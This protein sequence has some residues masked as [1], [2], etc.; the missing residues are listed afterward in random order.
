MKKEKDTKKKGKDKESKK[1]S[2]VASAETS[3]LPKEKS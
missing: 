2:S 3:N 1:A